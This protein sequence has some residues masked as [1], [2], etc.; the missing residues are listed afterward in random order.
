MFDL[1]ALGLGA[2]G[3][4][5]I[6]VV[7]FFAFR[8]K[9]VDVEE[10]GFEALPEEVRASLSQAQADAMQK[11]NQNAQEAIA[12]AENVFALPNCPECHKN[13]H[14]VQ[15]VTANGEGYYCARC[16]LGFEVNE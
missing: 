3:I 7:L 8:E 6:L 9:R 2:V 1:L 14:V 15:D 16:E 11:M 13:S 10:I 4:I 12:F 5:G